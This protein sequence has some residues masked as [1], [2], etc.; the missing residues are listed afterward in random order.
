MTMRDLGMRQGTRGY[1][2]ALGR[3]ELGLR[4]ERS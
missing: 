1:L 4:V 3:V 2:L